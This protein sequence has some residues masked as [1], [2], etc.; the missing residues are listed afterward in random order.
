MVK[1]TT[2]LVSHPVVDFHHKPN[3]YQKEQE[4]VFRK[5]I[6]LKRIVIILDCYF[7]LR[8]TQQPPN[9]NQRKQTPSAI[10]GMALLTINYPKYN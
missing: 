4:Y 7:D 10:S 5:K 8:L 6:R 1:K 9:K 2:K 3:A